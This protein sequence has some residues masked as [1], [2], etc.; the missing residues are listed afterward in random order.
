MF[1]SVETDRI[2]REIR[3]RDADANAWL[4]QTPTGCN[5]NKLK[6]TIE[7]PTPDHREF[8][9][10]TAFPTRV[11]QI[12]PSTPSPVG[13]FSTGPL[14]PASH[15]RFVEIDLPDSCRFLHPQSSPRHFAYRFRRSWRGSGRAF[16]QGYFAENVQTTHVP[17]HWSSRRWRLLHRHSLINSCCSPCLA[18]LWGPVPR[19]DLGQ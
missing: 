18:P 11:M 5:A 9:S 17:V 14:S 7:F 16:L 10:L 8:T 1:V 19:P 3:R 12:F 6:A 4:W 13:I 15:I 2:V